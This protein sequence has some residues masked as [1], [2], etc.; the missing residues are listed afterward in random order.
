M[1]SE[2][3]IRP[4]WSC[5]QGSLWGSA[6]SARDSSTRSA[7]SSAAPSDSGYGSSPL[8][9]SSTRTLSD[10]NCS[11]RP[12][13]IA[14][15]PLPSDDLDAAA[16]FETCGGAYRAGSGVD[17]WVATL[18]DTQLPAV[19]V[20]QRQH[21]R[22]TAPIGPSYYCPQRF[23]P[24]TLTRQ[25]DRAEGFVALLVGEQYAVNLPY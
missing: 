17:A 21:P 1:I 16:P 2:C 19:P 10:E 15:L 6:L 9:S 11:V 24:C 12:S 25:D 8:E 3:N 7:G 5:S 14:S 13:S 4:Q 20:E 22:R 18:Q 23:L